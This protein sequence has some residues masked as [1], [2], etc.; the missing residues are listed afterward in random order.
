MPSSSASRDDT[1]FIS[2]EVMLYFQVKE[3]IP[4]WKF[5]LQMPRRDVFAREALP[6][7]AVSLLSTTLPSLHHLH[8]IRNLRHGVR[9]TAALRHRQRAQ[10]S[11]QS[12]RSCLPLL[13][14]SSIP[15]RHTTSTLRQQ[16]ERFHKC[17]QAISQAEI[18]DVG[19]TKSDS[20]GKPH[21]TTHLWR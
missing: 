19:T 1:Q 18:P 15:T 4:F 7:F 3:A 17:F 9:T 5:P 2:K 13:P 10:A 11:T 6:P 8:T 14:N 16:R 20:S 21:T 12:I